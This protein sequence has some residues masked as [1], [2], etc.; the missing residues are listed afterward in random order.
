MRS[1][2]VFAAVKEIRNRFLLCRITSASVRS[3]HIDSRQPSETINQ[4]LKLIAVGEMNRLGDD[5]S[6]QSS[7]PPAPMPAEEPS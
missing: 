6:D 2:Y 7:P 5:T 4:S 1:E 3:L